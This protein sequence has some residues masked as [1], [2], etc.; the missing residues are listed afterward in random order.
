MMSEQYRLRFRELKKK[1]NI[2]EKMIEKPRRIYKNWEHRQLAGILVRWSE[3]SAL[4]RFMVLKIM[5]L[6][7]GKHILEFK[8]EIK[9]VTA[10]YS[11]HNYAE[12][13]RAMKKMQTDMIFCNLAYGATPDDYL[14]FDFEKRSTLG[15]NSFITNRMRDR[16]CRQLNNLQEGRIFLDKYKSYQI[17]Q[18]YYG[19]EAIKID[20]EDD[21][22]A[23]EKFAARHGKFVKKPVTSSQGR[24]VEFI[25]TVVSSLSLEKIFRKIVKEGRCILE[26][27]IKQAGSMSKLHSHSVNTIRC[28]TIKTNEGVEVFYP[29]LKVGR[30]GS[31]IDNG[32]AGGILAGIDPDTG[33][34]YTTGVDEVGERF[35][36]HPDTKVTLPGY[37]IPRWEE[38]IALA[39]KLALIV[40]A[41]KYVGWDL[42]LAED[43]WIMV[44]GNHYGQFIGQQ[45]PSQMGRKKEFDK[46]FNKAK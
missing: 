29:F 4:F 9:R 40:P 19:R 16:Y 21:F 44:E 14:Y 8:K 37:Q 15:R 34:V 13:S 5:T 10:N 7:W 30:N 12:D 43:G 25:D 3:R 33:V 17:F 6:L 22:S 23:F 28:T 45:L 38:L 32:G 35:I 41:V 31:F 20:S 2:I 36:L 1:H 42:A 18:Q 24:G 39:K 46:I 27:P 11:T 26:E